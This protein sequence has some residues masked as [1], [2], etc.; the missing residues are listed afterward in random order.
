MHVGVVSVLQVRE[1]IN[2]GQPTA[3]RCVGRWLIAERHVEI[4]DNCGISGRN[5]TDEQAVAD[6]SGN[7]PGCG[8][9]R[10]G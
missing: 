4:Q 2:L 8:G 9:N 6:R 1:L 10:E 7:R 3:T 5:Y